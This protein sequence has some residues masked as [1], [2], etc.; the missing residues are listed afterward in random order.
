[1]R[2]GLAWRRTGLSLVIGGVAV[3]R[4][5]ADRTAAHPVAGGIVVGLGV[6]LLLVTAIIG[7]RRE[8]ALATR[9]GAPSPFELLP[10]TVLVV[11]G[12]VAIAAF[13]VIG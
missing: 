7:Y 1:V 5:I 3:G 12:G 4:G 13:A 10:L 8:V 6:A 9:A 11:A 2:T